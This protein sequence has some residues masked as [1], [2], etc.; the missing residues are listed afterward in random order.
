MQTQR[1]RGSDEEDYSQDGKSP[2]PQHPD[3]HSSAS[4]AAGMNGLPAQL[5]RQ[6]SDYYLNAMNSGMAT[7]PPHLRSE[8]QPSPRAQS[9]A[10]YTMPVS[11]PQQ[12][13]SLTSNPSAGYNPPQ[14]LEPPTT[15]GQ[16]QPGS[17]GNS[18]HM[19]ST[20]GW[21]SPH[22]SLSTAQH[23]D[24]AYP[25]PNGQ[26]GNVSAPQ[27]YYQQAGVQPRPHSTAPI[28]DHNQLR[29]QE[30]WAHPQQ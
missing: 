7:M 13:P 12:R 8:M 26:F 6:S 24:Y 25:D 2:M 3:R 23:S 21:Q 11:A 30:M 9:P 17:G 29:G 20:M 22:T 14:I 1:S 18:P 19:G 28:Y 27:M 10:Q 5:Q 4:P 16:Q 15:N